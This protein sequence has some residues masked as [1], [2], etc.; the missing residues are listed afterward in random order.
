MMSLAVSRLAASRFRY[1]HYYY[2]D[3]KPV[4]RRLKIKVFST[5]YRATARPLPLPLRAAKR[6]P[7]SGAAKRQCHSTAQCHSTPQC[8]SATA[9]QNRATARQNSA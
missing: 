4:W 6:R 5:D 7:R 9:R 8:H 1:Q 3:A 2:Y